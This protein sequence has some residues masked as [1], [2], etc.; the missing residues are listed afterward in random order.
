[1][2]CPLWHNLGF[3]LNLCSCSHI[4][5]LD[6]YFQFRKT[7]PA[8]QILQPYRT[9]NQYNNYIKSY[10]EGNLMG[11]SYSSCLKCAVITVTLKK[12]H[13]CPYCS[14]CS[15][16]LISINEKMTLMCPYPDPRETGLSLYL[17]RLAF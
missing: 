14:Y 2:H 9:R 8:P 5:Q 11:R 13:F 15:W 10:S 7:F 12:K 6:L 17:W 1:M 16:T 4:L 3:F